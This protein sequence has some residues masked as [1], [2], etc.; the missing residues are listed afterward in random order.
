MV[1]HQ[2]YLG[3]AF[4]T[5]IWF[6]GIRAREASMACDG[7]LGDCFKRLNSESSTKR[8]THSCQLQ[9]TG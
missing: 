7:L 2:N 1:P 5:D 8:I 6:D 4:R 3:K 9:P